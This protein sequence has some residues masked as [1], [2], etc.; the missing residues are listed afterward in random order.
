MRHST[1]HAH[2]L[3]EIDGRTFRPLLQEITLTSPAFA[4]HRSWSAVATRV[5]TGRPS[6]AEEDA[7]VGPLLQAY[8]TSDDERWG[9][10]LCAVCFRWLVSMH[11][12]RSWWMEGPEDV[13][14]TLVVCFLHTCQRIA[15]RQVNHGLR[16][17]LFSDTQRRLYDI[18]QHYR[19]ESERVVST[20]PTFLAT[21][22]DPAMEPGAFDLRTEFR[23]QLDAVDAGLR[24]HLQDGTITEID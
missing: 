15:E 21:T 8:A 9:T 23:E 2:L 6:E 7:L 10:I 16:R 11:L 4:A 24:R 5:C 17:H 12:P 19:R 22:I 20:D 3:S 13:W 14:Q 18:A 1:L